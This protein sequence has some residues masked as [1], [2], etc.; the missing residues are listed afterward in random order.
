MADIQARK[1]HSL[2]L[3]EAK[4]LA[5]KL[6]DELERDFQLSSQ[7]EG[8]TL[9]FTRSGVKGQLEVTPKEVALEISLGFMLKAFKSKIQAEVL[10]NLDKNF[11]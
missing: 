3:D 4:K 9:R 8:N 6:A 1:S 10:K 5:Q 11:A 7:W 2:S